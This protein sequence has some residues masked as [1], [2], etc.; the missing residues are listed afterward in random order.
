[1]ADLMVLTHHAPCRAH[2]KEALP[3]LQEGFFCFH[4]RD[5]LSTLLFAG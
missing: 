2:H 1:M 3:Q 4:Q 5:F